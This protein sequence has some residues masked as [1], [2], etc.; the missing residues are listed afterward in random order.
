MTKIVRMPHLDAVQAYRKMLYRCL[1]RDNDWKM[2]AKYRIEK[3]L[4]MD[5]INRDMFNAR[6]E[7]V[8]HSLS[9]CAGDLGDIIIVS[10]KNSR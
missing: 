2:R 7:A 3:I 8:N 1:L 10:P 6:L 5:D 9:I 4:T